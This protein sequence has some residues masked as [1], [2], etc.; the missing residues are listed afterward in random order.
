MMRAW[1]R[2]PLVGPGSSKS[3]QKGVLAAG[4]FAPASRLILCEK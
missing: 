4:H 1:E 2:L 3:N